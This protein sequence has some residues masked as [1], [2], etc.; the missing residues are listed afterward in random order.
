MS[1]PNIPDTQKAGEAKLPGI[2]SVYEESLLDPATEPGLKQASQNSVVGTRRPARNRRSGDHPLKESMEDIVRFNDITVPS[3]VRSRNQQAETDMRA[4]HTRGSLDKLSDIIRHSSE[5][6]GIELS[7]STPCEIADVATMLRSDETR[8][9]SRPIIFRRSLSLSHDL[10][11]LGDVNA[12]GDQP[13][14]ETLKIRGRAGDETLP[15]P[16]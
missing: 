11:N 16:R 15:L 1:R 6:H 13:A 14:A 9:N 8:S 10:L 12:A 7:T 4:S 3:G 2:I 5:E